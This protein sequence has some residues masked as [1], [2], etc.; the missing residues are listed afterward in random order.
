MDLLRTEVENGFTELRGTGDALRTELLDAIV[1]GLRDHR[2]EIVTALTRERQ[3]AEQADRDTRRLQR[4]LTEAREELHR[5]QL[6]AAETAQPRPEPVDPPDPTYLPVKET[7]VPETA[8]AEESSSPSPGITAEQAQQLIDLLARLTPAEAVAPAPDRPAADAPP[9]DA[10]GVA[11]LIPA[12]LAWPAHVATLLKAA[13]VNTV[14]IAC[15]PH[16]WEFLGKR[17]EGAEHFDQQEAAQ[18][19]R[20]A[21]QEDEAD[22]LLSGRSV[23]ALL[24]A[25]RTTVYAG[26]GQ[27]V[28]TWALAVTCYERI[29]EVVN[30]TRPARDEHESTRPRIV[31][32]DLTAKTPA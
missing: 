25:L 7:P 1:D 32:D 5:L 26:T 12:T 10:G 8:H 17:V 2:D 20:G 13:A 9:V 19:P 4:R 6:R 30:S 3:S 27:D 11:D 22:N 24:N 21:F 31:L 16:T 15:N 29:A 23:I 28:E 14:A 18:R